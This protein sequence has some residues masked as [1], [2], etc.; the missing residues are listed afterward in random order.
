[1]LV[2]FPRVV[3]AVRCAVETQRLMVDRNAEVSEDKRITLRIGVNLG[4]VIIDGNDI[5]GDGST[6]PRDLR[7]GRTRRHLHLAGGA[8]PGSRQT[9]TPIRG[10]GRAERQEHRPAAT[11]LCHD[12]CRRGGIAAGRSGDNAPAVNTPPRGAAA[13]RTA[14]IDPSCCPLPTCRTIPSRNILPTASPTI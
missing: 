5:Y 9:P 2:E 14:A 8:R 11:R 10:P 7:R 1:M 12:R 6:S 4:D 3:D 13:R